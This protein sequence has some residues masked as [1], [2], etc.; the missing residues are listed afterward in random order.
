MDEIPDVL[1]IIDTKREACAVKEARDK[2]VETIGIV[3]SNS[4]PTHVDI[5]VPMNDDATKALDYVLTLVGEAIEK[6]KKGKKSKK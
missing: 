5:A 1:F 2:N 6:G 4:D 3:D